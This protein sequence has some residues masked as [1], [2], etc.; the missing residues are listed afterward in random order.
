MHHNSFKTIVRDLTIVKQII[1]IGSMLGLTLCEIAPVR[2]ATLNYSGTNIG[3]PTFQSL[4]SFEPS[5]YSVFEFT[6][7]S[8]VT[9]N[10]SSTSIGWQ[11]ALSLYQI[12]FDPN[13]FTFATF[14]NSSTQPPNTSGVS[15]ST[16]TSSLDAGTN[17]FLVTSG[18]RS[19]DVGNF[20]NSIS[21]AGNI[22]T[23]NPATTVPEPFTIV[24]TLIGGTVAIRTRKKLIKFR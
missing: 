6:V 24:G 14:K 20:S 7:D 13:L 21:G 2:A 17:Y 12:A 19:T 15:L 4:V 10:F 23:A 5:T 16:F 9:Y 18:L 3:G 8:T 22:L 1:F 11:N